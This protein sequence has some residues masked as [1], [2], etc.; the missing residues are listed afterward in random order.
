MNHPNRDSYDDEPHQE[1]REET[2]AAL[3]DA[4][5]EHATDDLSGGADVGT[6]LTTANGEV[7][8]ALPFVLETLTQMMAYGILYESDE[9]RVRST[10]PDGAISEVVD[11]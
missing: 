11:R 10:S 1:E 2:R 3:M 8:H 7:P 6:V 4:V 5:E 9:G